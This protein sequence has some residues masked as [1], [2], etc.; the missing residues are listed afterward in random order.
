[1]GNDLYRIVYITRSRRKLDINISEAVTGWL[2]TFSSYWPQ[3]AEKQSSEPSTT[4]SLFPRVLLY[5]GR[6]A[7]FPGM[8]TKLNKHCTL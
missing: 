5:D 2:F 6:V 4:G 3:Y 1:V 8:H 7:H